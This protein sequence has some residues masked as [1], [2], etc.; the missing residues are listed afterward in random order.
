MD[1]FD[2]IEQFA[3]RVDEIEG[4]VITHVVAR[5]DVAAFFIAIMARHALG[6]PLTKRAIRRMAGRTRATRTVTPHPLRIPAEIYRA[7]P[8]AKAS[9]GRA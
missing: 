3:Q 4:A 6:K 5:P 8:R 9:R 1:A 7:A 2:T